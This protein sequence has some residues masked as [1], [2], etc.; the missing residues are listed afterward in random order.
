MEEAARGM[1]T[2]K[3]VGTAIV[4][5]TTIV[6]GK[7]A[8]GMTIGLVARHPRVGT[9]AEV[10]ICTMA[11]AEVGHDHLMDLTADDAL[12]T[13]T[14]ALTTVALYLDGNRGMC[15]ICRLSPR[16]IQIAASSPLSNEPSKFAA[17]KWTY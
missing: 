7:A 6:I 11:D 12:Q 5:A 9:V 15:Q 3:T 4:E 17:S 1:A 14:E 13:S 8:D 16:I 10:R 2:A